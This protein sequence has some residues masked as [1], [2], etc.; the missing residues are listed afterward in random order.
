M[1]SFIAAARAR[2][3]AGIDRPASDLAY[4]TCGCVWNVEAL[5]A[6]GWAPDTCPDCGEPPVF[7]EKGDGSA[8]PQ[9]RETR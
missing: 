3:E 9:R 4:C 5:K 7:V 6:D 1:D 8:R 2:A